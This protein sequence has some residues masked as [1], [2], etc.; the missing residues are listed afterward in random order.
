VPHLPRPFSEMLATESRPARRERR[1]ARLRKKEGR[2]GGGSLTVSASHVSDRKRVPALQHRQEKKSCME[3]K[4]KERKEGKCRRARSI[5]LSNS[6]RFV[7]V[8]TGE[9]G[10]RKKALPGERG[11]RGSLYPRRKNLLTISKSPSFL[12][13]CR[14]EKGGNLITSGGKKRRKKRLMS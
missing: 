9:V 10:R 6:I 2:E 7:E 11:E 8:I 12:F 4:K 14:R 3:R 5:P 13:I 1:K